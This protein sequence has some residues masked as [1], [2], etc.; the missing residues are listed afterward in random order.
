MGFGKNDTILLTW[1]LVMRVH[2]IKLPAFKRCHL[3]GI[4]PVV[5]GTFI[6]ATAQGLYAWPRAYERMVQDSPMYRELPFP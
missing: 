4:A 3:N 2:N 6:A 5:G 1:Y